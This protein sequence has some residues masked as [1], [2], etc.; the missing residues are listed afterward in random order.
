MGAWLIMKRLIIVILSVLLLCLFGCAEKR[1][2]P[3]KIETGISTKEILAKRWSCGVIAGGIGLKK[4][5][6]KFYGEDLNLIGDV[7]VGSEML[8]RAQFGQPIIK[9][10]ILYEFSQTGDKNGSSYGGNIIAFDLI[11][12][13]SKVYK[14][15]GNFIQDF[16]I[17]NNSIYT[18]G[19]LNGDTTVCKV[20]IATGK[21]KSIL[22]KGIASCLIRNVCSKPC[23]ITDCELYSVNFSSGT[24]KLFYKFPEKWGENLVNFYGQSKDYCYV[25]LLDQVYIFDKFG[26]ISHFRIEEGNSNMAI[27]KNNQLYIF[28]DTDQGDSVLYVYDVKT[29][30]MIS[31]S[32]LKYP[33]LQASIKENNLV[34]LENQD[35]HEHLTKYKLD[36]SG[37]TTLQNDVNIEYD[38]SNFS[39]MGLFR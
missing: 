13:N 19:N 3:K 27:V 26:Y 17:I 29:K 24:K 38:G 14:A 9:N 39:L 30:K 18:V 22:L 7:P 31:K 21:T 10:N 12:G 20:D 28:C 8:G 34:T 32:I 16:C 23:I 4:S 6:L 15:E 35:T 37:R 33:V 11:T 25:T 2:T 1:Q 36:S 5:W